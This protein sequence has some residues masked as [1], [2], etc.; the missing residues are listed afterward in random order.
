[1]RT[2]D[3]IA[4]KEGKVRAN[5]RV[6]ASMKLERATNA[7]L[8]FH[9]CA[10][11]GEGA[12]PREVTPSALVGENSLGGRK[13]PDLIVATSTAYV[14]DAA[15]YIGQA[16]KEMREAILT[17]AIELAQMDLAVCEEELK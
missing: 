7:L 10:T 13:L 16:Y 4:L 5:R 6:Q 3:P 11:T 14:E 12:G 2:L 15:P 17:R 8:W 9:E 1:M